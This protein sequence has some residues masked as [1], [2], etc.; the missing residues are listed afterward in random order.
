MPLSPTRSRRSLTPRQALIISLSVIV[1]GIPAVLAAWYY[2][3]VPLGAACL[4]YGLA[5]YLALA[6]SWSY[7]ALGTRNAAIR[8][9]NAFVI[10]TVCV[11]ALL[12]L[13]QKE[14]EP[15]PAW[16]MGSLIVAGVAAYSVV[17]IC[18]LK[19]FLRWRRGEFSDGQ[20]DRKT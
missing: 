7:L 8:G 3:D 6:V 19:N 13:T 10:F 18:G 17:G 5:V 12:V 15:F 20:P 11:V 16:A 4:S 9:H 14:H 2:F 1:G